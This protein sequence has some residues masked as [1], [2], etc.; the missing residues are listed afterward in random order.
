[1]SLNNVDWEL[2]EVRLGSPKIISIILQNGKVMT[3]DWNKYYI[4]YN[5]ILLDMR[6]AWSFT[7]SSRISEKF[8]QSQGLFLY[9]RIWF[10]TIVETIVYSPLC[11]RWQRLERGRVLFYY[12]KDVIYH[13][14]CFDNHIDLGCEFCRTLYWILSQLIFLQFEFSLGNRSLEQLRYIHDLKLIK[15]DIT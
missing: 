15:P 7:G 11:I 5:G 13:L 12:F 6:S 14:C 4:F 9:F 10:C 3:F 8:V 1:M 2:L